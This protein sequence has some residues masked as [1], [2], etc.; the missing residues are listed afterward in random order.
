MGIKWQVQALG[1]LFVALS[2]T[3]MLAACGGGGSGGGNPSYSG[4]TTQATITTENAQEIAVGAY[5]GGQAGQVLVSPLSSG[6]APMADSS[7]LLT[8]A[9]MTRDLAQSIRPAVRGSGVTPQAIVTVTDSIPGTCGDGHADINI[10]V[11]DATGAFSGTLVFVAYCDEGTVL[12]GTTAFSGQVNTTT[13]DVVRFTLSYQSLTMT[14]TASGA[15]ATLIGSISLEVSADTLTLTQTMD[16]VLIDN[17]S[18]KTYWVN[19]YRLSMSA[20]AGGAYVDLS[21]SG[22]FY[23]P[24]RGYVEIVTDVPLHILAGASDPSSGVLVFLG[25]GNTS[26]RLTVNGGGSFLIE[27]DADGNGTYEWSILYTPN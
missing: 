17:V 7:R 12:D 26:A 16:M 19:N 24:D 5:E 13:G 2:A 18:G 25:A 4:I 11:N 14:E 27:A 20:D 15:S 6:A 8:F 10:S 1:P 23:D 22:R 3:L 9:A 21:I